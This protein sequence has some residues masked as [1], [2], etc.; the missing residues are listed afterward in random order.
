MLLKAIAYVGVEPTLSKP[1]RLP[2]IYTS[3]FIEGKIASYALAK[4]SVG[5]E[6]TIIPFLLI[7]IE[8]L[9]RI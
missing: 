4:A 1:F 5:V 8:L 2:D 9:E 7:S 3:K 6:P